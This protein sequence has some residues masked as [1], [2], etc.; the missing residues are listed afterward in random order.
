MGR[1]YVFKIKDFFKIYLILKKINNDR[2][3]I[4]D[5]NIV[6]RHVFQNYNIWENES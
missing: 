3:R 4:F 5:K 2:Y 6:S 1:K